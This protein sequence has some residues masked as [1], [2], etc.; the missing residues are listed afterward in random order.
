MFKLFYRISGECQKSFS[1]R[2]G[3]TNLGFILSV[4]VIFLFITLYPLSVLW[5]PCPVYLSPVL[6][7]SQYLTCSQQLYMLFYSNLTQLKFVKWDSLS[8]NQSHLMRTSLWQCVHL[9][10]PFLPAKGEFLGSSGMI[11]LAST[12]I[13]GAFAC[14]WCLWVRIDSLAHHLTVIWFL[15]AIHLE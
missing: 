11:C 10:L 6:P 3:V 4:I 1:Q 15:P 12:R 8:I 5:G 9:S 13:K 2:N 7:R 14:D